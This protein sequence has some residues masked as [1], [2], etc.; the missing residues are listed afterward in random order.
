M[1]PPKS[2]ARVRRVAPQPLRSIEQ[3]EQL[4]DTIEIFLVDHPRALLSEPGKELLDLSTG[5]FSLDSEYGKLIWHIWNERT[6]LVRQITGIAKEKPDRLE[7]FYQRFGKGAPGKLIVAGTRADSEALDRRGRR[8]EYLNHLRRWLA[9]LFPGAHIEELTTEA[10]LPDSLSPCYTRGLLHESGRYW[11][12]IGVGQEE[13]PAV[14]DGM[15]SFGLI[16]LDLLRARHANRVIAGLKVF[17]PQGFT[18]ATQR[19]MAWLS[20]QAALWEL[21]ETTTTPRLLDSSDAGNLRTRVHPPQSGVRLA[22]SSEAL[23]SGIEA[24][25]N[26]AAG[27]PAGAVTRRAG[28]D[29]LPRWFVNGLVFARQRDAAPDSPIVFG[30]GRAETTLDEASLPRLERL[31]RQLLQHRCAQ[32]A[33]VPGQRGDAAHGQHPLYRLLPEAW[34]ESAVLAAPETIAPDI[35]PGTLTAQ[36]FTV[37]GREQGL[38][39]LIG[40]T[41]ASRLL[42]MELKASEDIHHALQ[43]LDYWITAHWHLE[44]GSFAK[45]GFFAGRAPSNL[46]PRLLLVSPGLQFHPTCATILRY[47]DP[48]VEVEIVGLNE[49]WR[50]HLQVVFRRSRHNLRESA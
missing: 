24:L 39:D 50:E 3:L 20:R 9:Q 27:S 31:V 6:N 8:I 19:R 7:L 22:P 11:A 32:P 13:S 46:S 29:G 25:G 14:I 4:R 1:R 44:R 43:A 18:E 16:W 47:L 35:L 23:M 21:Y 33:P 26:S 15:L 40:L 41:Q 34:L 36:V 49:S 10:S 30:L 5:R 48:R 17:A 28:A 37:A 2:P 12:V 45:A 38:A 42:V